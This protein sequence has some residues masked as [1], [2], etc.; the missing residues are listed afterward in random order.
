MHHLEFIRKLSFFFALIRNQITQFTLRTSQMAADTLELLDHF[1]WK[2]SVHLV[3]ISMGGMIS[4]E[5]ADT[6]PTRFQSVTLTST[7]SKRN[8][9]TVSK[10][11]LISFYS[12]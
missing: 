12:L 3:G 6:E 10:Q 1:G 5:L 9:P 7:T 11:Q 2:D 8:V 4:L